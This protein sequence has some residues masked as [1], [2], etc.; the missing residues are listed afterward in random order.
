[1]RPAPTVSV[2]TSVYNGERWIG[3]TI[4]G[5]LGQTFG[6]FEYIIV[7]DG[8]TDATPRILAERAARDARISIL[9]NEKNLGITPTH[10]RGVAAARGEFI[11]RQDADDVSLPTRL[12]KQVAWLRARPDIVCVTSLIRIVDESGRHVGS[13]PDDLE[14]LDPES[15][16]RLLPA[17]NCLAHST[18]MLRADALKRFGY[19]E[20][21]KVSEDYDLW[22]RLAA[23]GLKMD[24]IPEVLVHY[25]ASGGSMSALHIR[26]KPAL[27]DLKF[28][29][30][31]LRRAGRF[32]AF[33][34]RM[35]R[36]MVRSAH[37]CVYQSF[38]PYRDLRRIV[39]Y[40]RE[41]ASAARRPPRVWEGRAAGD[42]PSLMLVFPSLGMG[43]AERV[44]LNLARGLSPIFNLHAVVTRG[45]G[46]VWDELFRP[47]CASITQPAE[48]AVPL[49]RRA[50]RAYFD[51]AA[52]GRR[53]EG[54]IVTNAVL[55][56]YWLADR[57]RAGRPMRAI[58]IQHTVGAE[59]HGAQLLWA[60][61][62]LDKRVCISQ[63]LVDHMRGVYAAHGMAEFADRLC[64][65]RNGIDLDRYRRD[66]ASAGPLPAG[67]E[68]GENERAVVWA[69]RF[70]VEKDPLLMLEAAAEFR[71]RGGKGV[72]FVMAG[73]GPLLSLARRV[74]GQMGV[75]DIVSFPGFLGDE[76]MR[77]LLGHAWLLAITSIYEGVPL[78]AQEALAMDVP[79]ISTAVGALDELVEDGRAGILL[80][81]TKAFA[82]EAA[83]RMLRLMDEPG[84]YAAMAAAARPSLEGKYD[85]QTMFDGYRSVCEGLV[86]GGAR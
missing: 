58:D 20:N 26:N 13:W 30:D 36:E 60:A 45:G 61:R 50:V 48:G 64:L 47:Y 1:M 67:I 49:S 57:R 3:E 69:G 29:W 73:D 46:E 82:A 24:K 70:S 80:P 40:I 9:T 54:A 10:N 75:A 76:A 62:L 28:K 19:N 66:A 17:R 79:V 65:V 55:A 35:A 42:K 77:G 16:A 11:A 84:A 21:I 4:D 39:P 8:S 63:A 74:A 32:G 2:L 5:I 86:G 43:G 41:N 12:E 56:Y 31:Y 7:D 71:R 18:S 81:A 38:K 72:R 51:A 37:R 15:I 34:R 33:E 22:L 78:V 23:A 14:A 83:A 27:N 85:L 53:I 52:E 25:R 59:T 6:D 44:M 68:L